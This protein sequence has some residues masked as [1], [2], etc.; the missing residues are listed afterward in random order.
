MTQED[1]NFTPLFVDYKEASQLTGF[2]KRTLERRI[3][4][5]TL[6][7]K[8]CGRKIMIDYPSIVACLDALPEAYPSEAA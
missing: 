4:D 8:R 7:A 3:K 5:G 2:C 1:R 6:T